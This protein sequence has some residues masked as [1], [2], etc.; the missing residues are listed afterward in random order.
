MVESR[1][2]SWICRE[3]VGPI[4]VSLVTHR[5]VWI[6]IRIERKGGVGRGSLDKNK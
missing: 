5:Q 3:P 1:Q 2:C 4:F 6:V